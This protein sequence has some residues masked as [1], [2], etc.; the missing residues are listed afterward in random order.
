M[1]HLLINATGVGLLIWL[2]YLV[3]RRRLDIRGPRRRALRQIQTALWMFLFVSISQT[4]KAALPELT[5]APLPRDSW[6]VAIGFSLIGGVA[7]MLTGAARWDT[8]K[9]EIDRQRGAHRA[10]RARLRRQMNRQVQLQSNTKSEMATPL[11]DRMSAERRLCSLTDPTSGPKLGVE[12]FA[13]L[14]VALETE[15]VARNK[16]DLFLLEL[17]MVN[18]ATHGLKRNRAAGSLIRSF[19]PGSRSL[20]QDQRFMK[21]GGVLRRLPV[22]DTRSHSVQIAD[23]GLKEALFTVREFYPGVKLLALVG[24]RSRGLFRDSHVAELRELLQFLPSEA[25][26]ELEEFGET[27]SERIRFSSGTPDTRTSDRYQI[28]QDSTR[29]FR[30][31]DVME[32]A[33]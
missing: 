26:G 23:A 5:L 14:F 24:A 16:V 9:R 20:S 8:I 32:S 17:S 3:R 19:Y 10:A 15:L 4:I 13:E 27:R 28:I 33:E 2:L 18:G 6:T 21:T 12:R 7:L 22:V 11:F 29:S 31:G 1:I 30:A 25:L